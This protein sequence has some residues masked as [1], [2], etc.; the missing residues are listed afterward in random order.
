LAFVG[1][2]CGDQILRQHIAGNMQGILD[3]IFAS[4][5]LNAE[6]KPKLWMDIAT[7]ELAVLVN[8]CIEPSGQTYLIKQKSIVTVV[9]NVLTSLLYKKEDETL[10]EVISRI[11]N[12]LAKISR[13]KE[14]ATNIAN[15][16]NLIMRGLMY[17]NK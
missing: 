11:L 8:V 4:F 17:F 7:R 16:K 10:C 13:D 9:D 12:L 14:G 3:E 1:N 15:S 2:L 6:T 5:K